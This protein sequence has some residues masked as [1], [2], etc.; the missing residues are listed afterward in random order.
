MAHIVHMANALRNIAVLLCTAYKGGFFGTMK[1]SSPTKSFKETGC[2]RTVVSYCRGG[3]PS[4]HVYSGGH[5]DPPL[6][7]LDW[8]VS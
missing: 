1:A 2:V 5:R 3:V 8:Y 6:H 7:S 4:P